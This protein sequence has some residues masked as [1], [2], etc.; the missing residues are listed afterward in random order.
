MKMS[1][2]ILLVATAAIALAVCAVAFHAQ[3]KESD[4]A[5]IKALEANVAASAAARD[6]D[7]IM[8]NY[9]PDETLV[10]FDVIP[11]RQYVGADAYKK[12]WQGFLGAFNGPI[13]VE[14]SDLQIFSDGKLAYA[15]YIQHSTGTG[16]DGKPI[17]MT[18]RITDVLRKTK[19]KWLIVHE[20]VSVP[21][22]IATGKADLSSKP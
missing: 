16:K 10:V 19:G 13:T 7:A 1:R 11:P 17:D 8:K 4:E 12:D 9:V 2:S 14:N 20:H 18:V 5:E 3:A 21:V 15:H 22:D 6:V